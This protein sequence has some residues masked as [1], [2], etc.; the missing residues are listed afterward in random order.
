M[1]MLSNVPAPSIDRTARSSAGKCTQAQA[2]RYPGVYERESA[3]ISLSII[4]TL[5]HTHNI[6]GAL[7][8]LPCAP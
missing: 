2:G 7:N 1:T 6:A 8:I 3:Y 4:Y 5:G